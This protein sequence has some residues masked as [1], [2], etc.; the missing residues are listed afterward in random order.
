MLFLWAY[1]LSISDF[2]TYFTYFVYIMG[3]K[4]NISHYFTFLVT[5]PE[6]GK[7]WRLRNLPNLVRHINTTNALDIR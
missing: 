6:T 2:I 7:T 1:Y 3:R 4:R 5:H